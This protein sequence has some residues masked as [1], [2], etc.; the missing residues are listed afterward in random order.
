MK[1]R[2]INVVTVDNSFT[3]FEGSSIKDDSLQTI[4]NV[5]ETIPLR[6]IKYIK[7]FGKTHQEP[8]AFYMAKKRRRTNNRGCKDFARFIY[9]IYQ[10]YP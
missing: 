1:S 7:Y 2:D 5:Q 10:Y 9:S 4:A 3:A 6:E 8:S